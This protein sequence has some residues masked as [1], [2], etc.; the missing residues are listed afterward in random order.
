MCVFRANP[1]SCF[2]KALK[3][4]PPGYHSL[5]V[6]MVAPLEGA[7]RIYWLYEYG[8]CGYVLYYFKKFLFVLGA[9]SWILIGGV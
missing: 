6:S 2:Q 7:F 9:G 4:A 5:I 8:V 3:K 1:Q